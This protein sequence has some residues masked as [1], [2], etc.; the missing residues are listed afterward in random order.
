MKSYPAF[1]TRLNRYTA[2]VSGGIVFA[3]SILAV[4]ESVM[5]NGFASPTTWSLNLTSGVF[6][7]AA[8]LGSSWAFQELGH[9][10]VDLVRDVVDN[11]SKSENR[12]PRRV[13]SL[14]GYGISFVVI[15]A[16]LYGGWKLCV[17]SIDLGQ[18][19]P[20]NFHFPLI[21]S[22]SAI[23][24]GSVLMLLTIFFI[25]VDLAKGGEKYL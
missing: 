19:A 8:F 21:I 7:W 17:R 3:A 23:V 14:I 9:V 2:Y 11:H 18:L 5:R 16:L 4:M 10:C 25:I 22:Y 1:M 24:V 13:M 12:M 20:Y 6:I 15:V